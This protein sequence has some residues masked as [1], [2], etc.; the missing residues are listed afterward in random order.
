MAQFS[1][2]RHAA[3]RINQTKQSFATLIGLVTAILSDSHLSNQEIGLLGD[4]L[5]NNA[6][7]ATAWPGDVILKRISDV[8][9]DGCIGEG[10]REDLLKTLQDL[11]GGTLEE[12]VNQGQVIMLDIDTVETVEFQGLAFCLTGDFVMGRKSTCEKLIAARGGI[13]RDT[14]SKKVRYLVAGGHGSPEWKHGKFGTKIE[15]AQQLKREGV[16]I[17]I[18]DEHTFSRAIQAS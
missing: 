5:R 14:V 7:L 11:A 10:E 6:A 16:A 8:M 15:R 3:A 13:V 2:A 12:G 9:A 4:W 18:I 1:Y 17:L